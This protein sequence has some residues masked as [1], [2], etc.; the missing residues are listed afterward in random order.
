MNDDN[1]LQPDYYKNIEYYAIVNSTNPNQLSNCIVNT[2]NTD[3]TKTI[4]IT[5]TNTKY[6]TY[7]SNI[8]LI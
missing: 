6:K 7:T 3:S 4:T 1:Y 8:S 5:G 2:G